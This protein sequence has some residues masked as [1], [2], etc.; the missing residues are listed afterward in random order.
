MA[1]LTAV[2]L[3]N[4]RLF[5]QLSQRAVQLQTAAQVS[6][7]ATSILNL[8]QLMTETVELIRDRFDLYYVGLFMVDTANKW[9]VLRAG[10]GEAGQIQLKERHRLKVGGRSMIGWCV[11]NAQPRI[12]YDVGEEATHFDNPVLPETRS[13]LALPLISRGETI[14][15]LTV[16][17]T[18]PAAYSR[19]D[20]TTLQTMADQLAN[21]IQ[22]ARFFEQIQK[23]LAETESLYM[24]SAELNTAQSYEDILSAVCQHTMLGTSQDAAIYLFDRPWT[25]HREPEWIDVVAGRSE[26][27]SEVA[28][29]RYPR[30]TFSPWTAQLMRPDA[31]TLVEDITSDTRMDDDLRADLLQRYDAIG[32]V[33]APLVVGG[34]WIGSIRAFYREPTTFPEAEVR[35][36]TALSGQAAV[37]VQG[38]RQ[39]QEIRARARRE[40]LIREIT[41]KIR[42]STDLDTILQTTITE[43]S[44]ALGTSHGAIRLGTNESPQMV[45]SRESSETLPSDLAP[46]SSD[47]DPAEDQQQELHRQTNA[48]RDNGVDLPQQEPEQEPTSTSR[49]G[50]GGQE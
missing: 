37:V 28:R 38:L 25:E 12:A 15:A 43:V 11:A 2:A 20:V 3:E 7:A 36:L 42:A 8:D 49:V 14:G 9:A 32:A 6:Q 39:L 31:L 23:A 13:E 44:R 10:T 16:Q 48:S 47:E 19:E 46:A 22:N 27:P 33:F 41:G 29:S 18:L 26:L 17:S 50:K 21:A 35:R 34:Q 30:A 1:Q 4:A 5:G 40:A 24:A 45:N